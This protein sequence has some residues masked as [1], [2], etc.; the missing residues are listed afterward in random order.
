MTHKAIVRYYT[1]DESFYD[2]LIYVDDRYDYA[3]GQWHPDNQDYLN[4]VLG[5]NEAVLSLEDNT[6]Y[7]YPRR[8]AYIS[9]D[10]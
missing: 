1:N 6:Y 5:S 9:D 3:K 7:P 4:R 2:Y 8:V 10:G